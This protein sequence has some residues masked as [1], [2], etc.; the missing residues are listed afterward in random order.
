MTN[1][2][3]KVWGRR[4]FEDGT[5][6]LSDLIV[7]DGFD[8]AFS[9]VTAEAWSEFVERT[10]DSLKLVAG[11]SLF[12][13]GCGSGAFLYLPYQNDV[14]VGGA[15]YSES[16]IDF[17]R[18]AMPNGDFTVCEAN[19]INTSIPFDVVI[20]CAVFQYF[21]SLDYAREVIQRMCRKATRAVA[22][23]NIPDAATAEAAMNYRQTAFGGQEA[24]EERYLGLDHQ[25]YGREWSLTPSEN[26]A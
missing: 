8:T 21:G 24:Y 2:W 19:A 23:L 1:E 3:R 25:T 10:V 18:V 20:S 13:V 11:D 12:D 7:A 14:A 15:D 16:Q 26:R 4:R 6:S 9:A 22:I 5:P 17:A